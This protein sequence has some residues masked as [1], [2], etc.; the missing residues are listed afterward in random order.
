MAQSKMVHLSKCQMEEL[1]W[2]VLVLK[3]AV[4]AKYPKLSAEPLPMWFNTRA[5]RFI[6]RARGLGVMTSP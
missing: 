5:I 4:L 1:E 2:Q 3:A 6:C